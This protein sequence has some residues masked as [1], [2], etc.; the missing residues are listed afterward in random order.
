[1]KKYSLIPNDINAIDLLRDDSINR[2]GKIFQ[3]IKL[4]DNIE[5]SCSIAINGEWGSGKTFFVK[6]AK[7]ILDAY[8]ETSNIDDNTRAEIIKITQNRFSE[9]KPQ[10]TVYYDSWMYDNHKDPILSLMYAVIN[11]G[12]S[13]YS[14]KNKRSLYKCG[15]LFAELLASGV[16]IM[17]GNISS[18]VNAFKEVDTS[19]LGNGALS[20]F[21]E[22]IKGQDYFENIKDLES[23]HQMVEQFIDSLIEERGNR[24]V[25]FVDELD[26]CKP[27]FAITLLERIKHYFGDE[28]ITFVFSVDMM[29]LQSTVKS[30]YGHDFNST[31]YLDKFFDLRMQL[32]SVDY[33]EFLK[34][35]LGFVNEGILDGICIDVLKYFKFSLRECER[36]IQLINISTRMT[37]KRFTIGFPDENAMIFASLYILPVMIGLQMKD[38]NEY[39]EFISGNNPTPLVDIILGADNL[40]LGNL[41]TGTMELYDSGSKNITK[42]VGERTGIIS[43]KDRIEAIYDAFFK[44]TFKDS[45]REK[46][47]GSLNISMR[48]KQKLEEIN[49]LLVDYSDYT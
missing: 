35:R 45:Y 12:Q 37:Y 24:L 14:P 18:V 43:A 25:F 30:F 13:D 11:S 6:Q 42:K 41:I 2:N 7:L 33:E 44:H 40:V 46:N 10:S 27:D 32:P 21:L 49:S 38:M 31:R 1:M 5:D 28:R 29:Q 15:A 9:I 20:K 36:Y 16:S 8:N 39:K 23:V 19:S 34:S 17:S 48:T 26:R 3:F 47:I 4:L 22:E